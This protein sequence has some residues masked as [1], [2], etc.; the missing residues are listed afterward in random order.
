VDSLTCPA[1]VVELAPEGEDRASV[2]G[3]DY[4]QRVAEALA[5]A[6]VFWS[7]QVQPPL[8]LPTERTATAATDAPTGAQP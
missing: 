8:R 2:N 1:V 4:Q 6:L 5:G 3:S 7:R